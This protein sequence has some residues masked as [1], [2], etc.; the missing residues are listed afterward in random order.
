MMGGLHTLATPAQPIPVLVNLLLAEEEFLLQY[1][2]SK[3]VEDG[4]VS[5]K[6][7]KGRGNKKRYSHP[8][9][10]NSQKWFMS[11]R[12]APYWKTTG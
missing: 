8:H 1:G 4:R 9:A 7:P 11:E 5:W 2:W 10:V 12:R 6:P 3:C